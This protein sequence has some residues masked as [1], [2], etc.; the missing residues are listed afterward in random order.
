MSDKKMVSVNE[1]K[2]KTYLFDKDEVRMTGRVAEKQFGR[3]KEY[4]FEIY[5]PNRHD[6][7]KKWVRLSELWVV[8]FAHEA[9]YV[10]QD[11]VDAVR[12]VVSEEA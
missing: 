10:P 1:L 9:I 12:K 3:Q 11:L 4:M 7:W 6:S 2:Q 5:Q 8:R